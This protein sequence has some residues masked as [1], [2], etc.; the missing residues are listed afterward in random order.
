[1]DLRLMLHFSPSQRKETACMDAV[2]AWL[3]DLLTEAITLY[4]S[5]VAFPEYVAPAVS[6]VSPHYCFLN[7][8]PTFLLYLFIHYHV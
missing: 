3:H 1:M 6:E 7:S 5:S 8:T 4:A 2:S